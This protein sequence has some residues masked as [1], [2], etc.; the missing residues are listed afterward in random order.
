MTPSTVDNCPLLVNSL[1]EDNESDGIGD[2]CDPDDDN[3]G[4]ADFME[5]VNGNDVVD[6]GETDPLKADTDGDSFHDG[7]EVS[8]GSDPLNA[9]ST[10]VY[11]DLNEDGQVNAGD[12]LLVS[13]IASGLLIPTANQLLRGD[14]APLN[15]GVPVSDG[16]I[17]AA[18]MLLITRKA[19]AQIDF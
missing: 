19:L 2:A 18:D 8:F 15:A 4:L 1:Q 10:P 11:G 5:D 7:L 17:N 13:R 9:A 12:V 14:V 6:A 3:D 16:V